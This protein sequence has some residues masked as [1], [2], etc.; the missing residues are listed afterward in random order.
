[1]EA[2]NIAPIDFAPLV[3]KLAPKLQHTT[4]TRIFIDEL[5][6]AKPPLQHEWKLTSPDQF[7]LAKAGADA[8]QRVHKDSELAADLL[9]TTIPLFKTDRENYPGWLVCPPRLRQSV[10]YTGDADWLV[11]KPALDL[12]NPKLR[13]EAL[14][15]ILWRRTLAFVPLDMRLAEALAEL[16][17]DKSPE[18]DPDLRLEFALALMR[19][20]RV[21]RDDDGLRRWEA[22]ILADAGAASSIRL[23][24]HYQRCLR[25]RDTM[26]LTSVRTELA[27]ITSEDP[28]WKLRRAALHTEIG[29]HAKATKLIKEATVELERRHRRDR[30]SLI[31]KSHLAWASWMSRACDMWDFVGRPDL[32]LPRDFKQLDIDPQREIEY[33][34]NGGS[35]IEKDRREETVPVRPSFDE[36]H[37]REGNNTI[38]FGSGDPGMNLFYEFDQLTENVGIPL[39]INRVN[40]CA[41][42]AIAAI[43]ASSQPDIEWYVWLFRALHSYSD[44]QF[45][46]RFGRIVIAQMV[47]ATASAL[48][49][50]VGVA[51]TFWTQRFK[52]A[53]GSDLRNDWSCAHDALRLMLM[54]LSRLTVRMPPEQAADALCKAI[55]LSTDPLIAH[56]Q[57]IEAIGELAKYAAKAIPTAERGDFALTLFEFPL[58]SEKGVRDAHSRWPQI[59]FDIWNTLPVRN[60]ADVKSDHRVNQLIAAAQ[61]GSTDREQAIPQLAYL[62]IGGVLKPE[63]AAAFGNAL[64]SD[65]DAEDNG[66]PANTSLN[67]GVFFRLPA[68]E[69]IDRQ[70]RLSARLLGVDLREV[71]NLSPPACVFR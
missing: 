60:S 41:S 66:L 31:V 37:Y 5:R 55:E 19:D 36:G 22:V 1:L 17:D 27:K 64:W 24:A 48:I 45:E 67:A 30:N 16:V 34:E 58:P 20:A 47:D 18:I 26:D 51:V 12:L 57:L 8:H 46:R 62:A 7:P 9:K 14:F 10:A 15:E 38:R 53:R 11:R 3:E 68:P 59:A 43:D 49:S 21:S 4:A 2:H 63:E 65:L 61:K 13:A 71:M 33:I 29:E 70:A 32:P 54:T 6:K 69:S 42:A 40:V 35:K 50:I 23:A 52:D 28:I 25:A 44:K 39:H 56:Q